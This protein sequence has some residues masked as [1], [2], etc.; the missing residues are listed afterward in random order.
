MITKEKIQE[1]VYNLIDPEKQFLVNIAV[2]PGN[3]VIVIIDNFK[4][5]NLD[6]CAEISRK[7]ESQLDR[8]KE[9]FELEVTSPGL[10]QPFQVIQ[11]Y[12]KNLDKEVEVLQK[13]GIKIKAK[14]KSVSENGIDIELEKLIRTAK[15]K[16]KQIVIE[17]QFI[18]FENI[19]NTKIVLPF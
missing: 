5:I 13:N 4:G 7:I 19:K 8:N 14:L 16:K 2:N 12:Y 3:K 18:E 10:S 6:E 15:N 17:Q 1:I 9:D 11:Q